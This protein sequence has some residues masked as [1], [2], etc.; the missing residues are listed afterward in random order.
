MARTNRVPIDVIDDADRLVMDM[1]DRKRIWTPEPGNAMQIAGYMSAADEMFAGG[2][3]GGG[4]SDLILG[5]AMTAHRRSIIFRREYVQLARIVARAREIAGPRA[6]YNGQSHTLTMS[7]GRTIEFGA[8]EREDDSRKYQGRDHDLICFD[9][10]VHFAERQVDYVLGWLRSATP[11]QRCRVVFTSNPPPSSDGRWIV[12]RFAPWLSRA[13]PNPAAPGELRWFA[14]VEPDAPMVEVGGPEPIKVGDEEV[15]PISRTF[16]PGFL[17]ANPYLADDGEYLRRMQA[18]PEPIRSQLLY[19]DFNAGSRDDDWQVIPSAWIDAAFDRWRAA[20]A[21]TAGPVTHVA[22]DVSVGGRDSGTVGVRRGDYIERIDCHERME[23]LALAAHL[24][25]AARRHAAA[26]VVCDADGP[27][28]I[29]AEHLREHLPGREVIAFH[30]G[31]I[32]PGRDAAGELEFANARAWGYWHLRDLLD[33]ERGSQVCIPASERLHAELSAQRWKM[34]SG[35]GD[36][37]LWP[38][39]K[40][41][42]LI[43]HSPDMA[44]TCMM[45][46]SADATAPRIGFVTPGSDA[47]IAHAEAGDDWCRMDN[48]AMWT[49]R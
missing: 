35:R 14:R 1:L 38:K 34:Q 22:S 28:A 16:L 27:G 30:G 44:D 45:L 15:R 25:D 20:D 43:G 46:M 18:M 5:L 41:K 47:D 40:I 42:R 9:E 13:Y 21:S 39:E 31:A 2:C 6:R 3:A 17:A 23:G 11:G 12:E 8:M 29:F 32:A 26:S 33:P 36:V 4:K 10:A 49:T 19:G 7:D 24:I 48:P 37:I